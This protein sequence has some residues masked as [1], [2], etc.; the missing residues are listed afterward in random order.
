[1]TKL[2]E[3]ILAPTDFSDTAEVAMRYGS[4]LANAL[5]A[6]LHLLHVIETVNPTGGLVAGEKYRPPAQ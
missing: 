3:R 6:T 5:G 1:M 2:L 4:E